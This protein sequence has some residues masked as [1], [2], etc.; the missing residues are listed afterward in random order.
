MRNKQQLISIDWTDVRLEGL[1]IN[2]I[3]FHRL[4][5]PIP[6]KENMISRVHH[7]NTPQGITMKALTIYSDFACAA[8]VNSTLKHSAEKL[9][10]TVQW[11]ISP[12]RVDMLKFSPIAEEALTDALD[13]HLIVF[14]GHGV[15]SFPFW[16]RRWVEHWAKCRQIADAALA[17]FCEKSADALS[18]PEIL[19]LSHFAARNGL[20]FIFGDN[21]VVVQSS[22]EGRPFFIEDHLHERELSVS[23][24]R[25]QTL[26][27]THR[28]AYRGL[29]IIE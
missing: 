5:Q 20:N 22:T 28:D 15:L 25:P 7:L 24:I 21:M 14:T 16:L 6:K 18:M 3:G 26:D 11:N 2:Y 13:A 27:T 12:W 23:P 17:V 9:D 29:S 19:E 8:K 1:K 4:N 10:F